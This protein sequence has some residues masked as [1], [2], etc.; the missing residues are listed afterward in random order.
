MVGDADADAEVEVDANAGLLADVEA[1]KS[2]SKLQ[3]SPPSPPSCRLANP[4]R[5]LTFCVPA[6]M[7]L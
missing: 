7:L 3:A 6:S 4:V 1:D 5:H 2:G